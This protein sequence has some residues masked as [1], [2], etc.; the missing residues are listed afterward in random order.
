[1]DARTRILNVARLGT[2]AYAAALEMQEAMVHARM[3]DRIGDTLLILEHPHVYT[4]GRGADERYLL[5]RRPEVPVYRVSRGGQVTYHGPGQ[6]VGYPILKLEGRAR[7][8]HRYLRM[9]EDVMIEALAR[10]GVT[11]ARRQGLTGVWVGAT[12]I[13]SIGVGIRRWVT[14]HGFALNV[15]CDLSLFE[16]IVPCGITG[17]VMT[18]VAA[19]G[20]PAPS[21]AGFAAATE[22]SFADVFGYGGVARIEPAEACE[23]IDRPT[24]AC[25]AENHP[26]DG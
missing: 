5:A 25:E 7:D 18:S 24:I 1:M 13:G 12:K 2:V 9:L 16:A 8:V 3:R 14:L 10:R 26:H 19:L 4:L 23:L 11:S 21:M 15:C 6:L 22:E 17:C 20:H